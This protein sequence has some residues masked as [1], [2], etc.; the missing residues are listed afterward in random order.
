MDMRTPPIKIKVLHEPKPLKS[1]VSV[2][3]PRLA[4]GSLL[5]HIVQVVVIMII[6]IIIMKI[7]VGIVL[8]IVFEIEIVATIVIVNNTSS[9]NSR[10]RAGG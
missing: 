5:R 6:I 8:I 4:V 1:R 10:D 9:S 7:V 3:V 2:P